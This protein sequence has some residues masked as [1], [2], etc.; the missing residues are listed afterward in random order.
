MRQFLAALAVLLALGAPAAVGEE[1]ESRE[2][3]LDSL[4]AALKTSDP[5]A[6]EKIAAEI[7]VIWN[8][9]GSASMNLLAKRAK[10]AMD[11]G[12]TD[13]ALMHLNDLVRLA[14]EFAEGWNIRATVHFIVGAYRKSIADIHETLKREPR[15]FGAL[16]GLGLVYT[17]LGRKE[18]ALAA[19][20]AAL[21]VHPH[22]E[23][24]KEMV[25]MLRG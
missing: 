1:A 5:A 19:Y 6:A 21:A 22:L 3:R 23:G 10:R 7:Q 2:S 8:D 11:A 25:G 14:P 4:F 18:E 15:H 9:S 24:P 13:A 16:A 12:S 17:A 20:E